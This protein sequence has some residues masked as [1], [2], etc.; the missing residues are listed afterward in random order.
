MLFQLFRSLLTF[1]FGNHFG[2]SQNHYRSPSGGFP[3]YGAGNSGFSRNRR[4]MS[5]SD[6]TTVTL[7]HHDSEERMVDGHKMHH[8]RVYAEP[9]AS[10]NSSNGDSNGIVVSNQF[11][12]TTES[13][14]SH[15]GER[16]PQVAREPW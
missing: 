8:L 4:G 11:D 1:L 9:V 2:T 12:I 6:P 13:R 7:T 3:S 10:S 14:S 5:S 15:N 16:A